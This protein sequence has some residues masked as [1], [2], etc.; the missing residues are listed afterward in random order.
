MLHWNIYFSD[1]LMLMTMLMCPT[2]FSLLIGYMFAREFQ[3]RT[4][5][6]L[7][8]GP[9]SRY[10]VLAAKFIITIPVMT[11][12]LLLSIAADMGFGIR[13]YRMIQ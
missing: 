7:L 11:A 4:I 1:N 3:E 12:V 6:N 10:Q 2:L 8:T 5:N 13:S 9:K